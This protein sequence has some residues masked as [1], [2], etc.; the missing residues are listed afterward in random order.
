MNIVVILN[1]TI[2]YVSIIYSTLSIGLGNWVKNNAVLLTFI[3]S[4]ISLLVAFCTLVSQRQTQRNTAPDINEKVQL[5][6]LKTYFRNFYDSAYM[7]YALY[8][9]LVKTEFKIKPIHLFWFK[10]YN[11]NEY[12][13]ER[14]FYNDT[15]KL[16]LFKD[17][18]SKC[19][20]YFNGIQRLRILFEENASVENLKKEFK[21]LFEC[22]AI[23]VEPYLPLL[24]KVFEVRKYSIFKDIDDYLICDKSF[25]LLFKEKKYS[26]INF[27]L[28]RVLIDS[29]FSAEEKDILNSDKLIKNGLRGYIN[30]SYEILEHL[31]SIYFDDDSEK[32]VR[33]SLL[34]GESL[35]YYNTSRVWQCFKNKNFSEEPLSSSIT[36]KYLDENK[37][38]R[39]R[40]TDESIF[41]YLLLKES[42]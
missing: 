4:F 15:Q 33:Y 25:I 38:I 30:M 41:D 32:Y 18:I 28:E 14:T 21:F 36:Q 5:S 11:P 8:Y 40:S 34:L 9:A 2:S 1:T 19:L 3:V 16:A 23:I 31:L 24:L 39:Y 42:K 20:D 26:S 37:A 6:L 17:F 12:L 10:F 35:W 27:D 22:H 7:L 29:S 13:F